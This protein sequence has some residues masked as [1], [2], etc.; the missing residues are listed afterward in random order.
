MKEKIV[1]ALR[2]EYVNL[3]LSEKALSGV[4]VFIEKTGIKEEDIATRVKGDDVKALLI[5]IQGE[6]DSL[7]NNNARLTKENEDL[8]SKMNNK[9]ADDELEDSETTKMLKQLQEEIKSINERSIA[10]AKKRADSEIFTKVNEILK[11]KGCINDFVRK[12]TLSGFT[13]S[14]GDTAETLADK[15]KE[16]YDTNFKEAYGEGC[17]PPSGF[18][19]S[20][21]FK[22]GDFNSEIERL[23]TAG[24]LPPES[25]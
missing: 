2:N 11:T 15:Y 20:A 5:S 25:K 12:I 19:S 9:L 17:I 1:K 21:E 6:S 24:Y 8:K 22:Q 14:D 7:R 4:A 13:V 3:G 16:L 18:R 23:R 10:E